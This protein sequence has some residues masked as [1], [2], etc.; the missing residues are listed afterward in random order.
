MRTI[1]KSYFLILRL[2]SDLVWKDLGTYTT[3]T[4]NLGTA[5]ATAHEICILID[6]GWNFYAITL[7]WVPGKIVTQTLYGRDNNAVSYV[8][9][10]IN[11]WDEM[12][13]IVVEK[14]IKGG[15]DKTAQANIRDRFKF[16]VNS[17][18]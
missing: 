5:L 12:H 4:P 11:Q 13:T 18:N 6:D 2:N 7:P 10:H 8:L 14:M 16:C 15:E 17:K 1:P 3:S 9:L